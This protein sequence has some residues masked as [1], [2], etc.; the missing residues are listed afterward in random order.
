MFILYRKKVRKASVVWEKVRLASLLADNGGGMYLIFY[1]GRKTAKVKPL[2]FH[3]SAGKQCKK[4]HWWSFRV[5]NTVMHNS[6]WQSQACP[7]KY[8][9]KDSLL[10]TGKFPSMATIPSLSLLCSI[11]LCRLKPGNN[12]DTAQKNPKTMTC[13]RKT[14]NTCIIS[15]TR[16]QGGTAVPDRTFVIT[17]KWRKLTTLI[18]REKA[19]WRFCLHQFILTSSITFTFT[20]NDFGVRIIWRKSKRVLK[21]TDT[22]GTHLQ[23]TMGTTISNRLKI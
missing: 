7:P 22:Q 12:R 16:Q 23:Q 21:R 19:Q 11:H 4:K 13:A 15:S 6:L 8:F 14:H 18:K 10:C 2:P 5:N 9:Q 3:C 20:D 17:L 1:L